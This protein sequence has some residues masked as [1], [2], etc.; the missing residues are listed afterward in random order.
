[1]DSDSESELPDSA[2]SIDLNDS[3]TSSNSKYDD[4]INNN[5]AINEPNKG[6][7]QLNWNVNGVIARQAQLHLLI[8]KNNY[9][10]ITLQETRLNS[11]THWNFDLPGYRKYVGFAAICEN[12]TSLRGLLTFVSSGFIIQIKKNLLY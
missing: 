9:D 7:K 5:D 6:F 8:N 1:M 4:T 3:S 11:K 2:E 12:N 10:I